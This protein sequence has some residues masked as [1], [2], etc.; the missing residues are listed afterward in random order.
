M[1]I[2][3]F[4]EMKVK[5]SGTQT[6]VSRKTGVSQ[7]T[8]AKIC[9]G[10]TN[11]EIGTIY[12]IAAAYGINPA[13]FIQAELPTPYVKEEPPPYAASLTDDQRAILEM[14]K[15]DPDLA[16]RARRFVQFEK[17]VSSEDIANQKKVA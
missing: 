11:P 12:K 4:I 6:A 16:R 7:G 3:E 10:D 8:I 17:Q 14:L 9:S 5:E 2:K 13:T 1:K 15:D